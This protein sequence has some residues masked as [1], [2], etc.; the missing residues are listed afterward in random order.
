[1]IRGLV[2][3]NRELIVRLIVRG[4]AGQRQRIEAVI[5][6]GFN[7]WLSLPPAIVAL[8]GLPWKGRGRAVLADGS[9]RFFNI[10]EG[11]IVWDRRQ[12]HIAIYELEAAPLI[13]MALLEGHELTVQVRRRGKVV[14]QAL[15]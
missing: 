12:R 6:T 9:E 13:G 5:D 2:N 15:P 7:S 8:L 10:Y 11:I 3:A 4:P 1:M 14:I